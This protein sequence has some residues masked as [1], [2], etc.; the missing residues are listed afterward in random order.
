MTRKEKKEMAL[1]LKAEIEAKKG[2]LKKVIT[3]EERQQQNNHR[4]ALLQKAKSRKGDV[5]SGSKHKPPK[6]HDADFE[7]W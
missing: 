4:R 1:L 2:A 6:K 3:N 5:F 7:R